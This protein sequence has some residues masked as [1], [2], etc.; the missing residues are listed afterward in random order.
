[1]VNFLSAVRLWGG[2]AEYFPMLG[3]LIL[4]NVLL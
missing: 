4:R 3:E 2:V 1:M